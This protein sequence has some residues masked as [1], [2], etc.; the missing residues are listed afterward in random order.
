[1][2]RL[3]DLAQQLIEASLARALG[4]KLAASEVLRAIVRAIEDA[5]AGSNSLVAPNHFWVTLNE[6]DL[7]ALEGEHPQ[8]ADAL[9]EQVR[10]IM[11]QMGLR[12]DAPPRVLLWGASHMPP[13]HLQVKARWIAFNLAQ[14]DTSATPALPLPRRP[15]LI[16]D[17]QRQINL[18]STL[19]RVGRAHDNDVVMDDRRVSRHHL[20]LRWQ[21]DA[22][23]F[24]A[25]D[26]NSSG[27]TRLNGYPIKQ[28]T[29]EAGDVL[30]L[31]GVEIIYGEEFALQSTAPMS[32]VA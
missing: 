20:E 30:S 9:S 32:P 17:G 1:M 23:R 28:C 22:E 7:R 4:G 13:R 18:T 3:E 27:G 8:L 26:L 25:V 31:G 15:F 11:L 24:L 6:G 21:S 14:T 5:Q 2:H 29:L 19:V 10:Q 12:L 16:V